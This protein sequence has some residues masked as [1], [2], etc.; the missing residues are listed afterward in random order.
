M[1]AHDNLSPD[2]FPAADEPKK[3][4][5]QRRK[6]KRGTAPATE[7]QPTTSHRQRAARLRAGV[8]ARGQ[9]TGDKGKRDRKARDQAAI[10]SAADA[11]EASTHGRSNDDEGP[12]AAA[13]IPARKPLAKR[14][15]MQVVS[16]GLPGLGKR[17]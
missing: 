2:Q 15:S 10:A 7:S 14:G 8:A 12:M 4:R 5:S 16:G 13:P 6:D 11:R 9:R 3:S 1:S 17:R